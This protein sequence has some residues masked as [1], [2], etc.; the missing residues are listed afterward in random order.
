VFS[1]QNQVF[2]PNSAFFLHFRLVLGVFSRF[3]QS[4]KVVVYGDTAIATGGF[5]AKGTDA[6]GKPMDIHERWTDTWVKMPS[7]KWQCVATHGSTI[8]N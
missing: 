8:V 5:K 1:A 3:L 4:L 6:A 7:G 2:D